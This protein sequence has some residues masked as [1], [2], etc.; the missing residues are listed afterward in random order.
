[1]SWGGSGCRHV[2]L[3]KHWNSPENYRSI[4]Y[5][6]LHCTARENLYGCGHLPLNFLDCYLKYFKS[7]KRKVWTQLQWENVQRIFLEMAIYGWYKASTICRIFYKLQVFIRDEF[8]T[9]RS[10]QTLSNRAVGLQMVGANLK[11]C[12]LFLL[13]TFF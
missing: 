5:K 10:V 12:P 6:N 13:G 8:M 3:R 1:V 7:F 2:T 4:S 11:W 9:L